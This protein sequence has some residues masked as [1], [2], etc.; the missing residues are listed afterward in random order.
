MEVQETDKDKK[1]GL[2]ADLENME[3]FG[4]MA[5][6][7]E[8]DFLKSTI[9]ITNR[10]LVKIDYLTQ[11]KK[12]ISNHPYALI[13]REKDLTSEEYEELAKTVL[14]LCNQ[15][16]VPCYIH[17]DVLLAEKLSCPNVHISVGKLVEMRKDVGEIEVNFD[18][19]T[20][21]WMQEKKNVMQLQEDTE[22]TLEQLQEK[23]NI[24]QALQKLT[25]LS[26]SCH[27]LEDVQ[28]A[29]ACGATQ[30][31]LG[32]IFETEC[33]KG[34]KGKGLGFVKEITDYCKQHGNVPVFAIGGISP[35]NL[36]DVKQAGAQGGC[37]MSYLMEY[38]FA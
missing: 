7:E 28:T 17:S 8:L 18:G 32:T 25:G 4:K 24:Q 11:L 29:I 16:K 9:V 5:I 20:S 10:H 19:Q 38:P 36:E 14:E 15:E 1:N 13:L 23:K 31:V 3:A 34:L 22:N 6:S 37:M 26:V 33:K 2:D 35:E 30:I 12:V 27:S 21:G